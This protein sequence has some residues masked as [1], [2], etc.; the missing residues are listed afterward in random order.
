MIPLSVL[1]L[2]PVGLGYPARFWDL[3]LC[4]T[5]QAQMV[6]REVLSPGVWGWARKGALPGLLQAEADLGPMI[7]YKASLAAQVKSRKPWISLTCSV[8]GRAREGE[9]H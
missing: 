3:A 6:F 7:P 9:S 2:T 8:R 5:P 1:T 4:V